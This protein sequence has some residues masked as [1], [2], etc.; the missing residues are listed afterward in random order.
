MVNIVCVCVSGIE[1][2]LESNTDERASADLRIRKSQV[3]QSYS[4]SDS[5]D[6][7]TQTR[8]EHAAVS[9]LMPKTSTHVT[10]RFT[11]CSRLHTHTHIL[12]HS[13]CVSLACI[14][15][16]VQSSVLRLDCKEGSFKVH[17]PCV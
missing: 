6:P 8:A 11:E 17:L 14:N 3:R 1:R 9:L 16:S 5:P 4:S 10:F 13:V 2:Q 12:L 15:E 7:T